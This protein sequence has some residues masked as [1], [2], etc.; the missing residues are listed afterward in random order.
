MSE[1]LSQCVVSRMKDL[2]AE[3]G[4]ENIEVSAE[5]ILRLEM[6]GSQLSEAD[7]Y[8]VYD[9]EWKILREFDRPIALSLRDTL[10]EQWDDNLTE[11]VPNYNLTA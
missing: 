6:R 8:K 1:D 2:L 3:E 7:R 10:N 5:W 11:I 9:A 4:L